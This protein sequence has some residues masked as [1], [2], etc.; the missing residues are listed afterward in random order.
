MP[1]CLSIAIFQNLTASAS[2]SIAIEGHVPPTLF[3][4]CL[5]SDVSI[6]TYSLVLLV[7]VLKLRFCFILQLRFCFFFNQ[8]SPRYKKANLVILEAATEKRSLQ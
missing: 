5:P 6:P 1:A 7:W 4:L 8:D 2:G 3:K